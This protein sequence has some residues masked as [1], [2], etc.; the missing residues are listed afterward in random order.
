MSSIEINDPGIRRRAR[1]LR[2]AV[3]VAMVLLA[4][5]LVLAWVGPVFGLAKVEIQNKSGLIDS[6]LVGT[7]AMLLIEIA[8]FRLAQMLLAIG[9]GDL[10]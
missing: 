1:R 7:G 5:T 8:L 9:E 3:V 2:F 6:R 10:F 4:A